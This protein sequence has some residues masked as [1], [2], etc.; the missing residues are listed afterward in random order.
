MSERLGARERIA[1]PHSDSPRISVII[2]SSAGNQ[3]LLGALRA[4]QHAA[5][6]EIPF[7]TIVI[8]N[9][10]EAGSIGALEGVTGIHLEPAPVNLGLAGAGNRGRSI[11]RGDLLVLLHDDAEVEPGW[12]EALV[13]TADGHP[14]AGAIGGKVLNMDGSLQNAG[15]ILWRDG[16][17]TAPWITPPAPSAFDRLRAVDYC[18]TSSL[19]VRSATWDAVGGLDE[20]FYPVYYVDVDL[21]MSIRALGQIVLCE[22]ASRIRH[23]RGAS[24]RRPWQLFLTAR[25]RERFAAKWRVEL[26]EHHE[27][28]A[29]RSP[30]AIDRAIARAEAFHAGVLQRG[31]SNPLTPGEPRRI[32]R[33]EHDLLHLNLALEVHKAY[34]SHLADQ[35]D[36]LQ[37]TRWWQLREPAR[38]LLDRFWRR[39]RS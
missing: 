2:P 7:E 16:S 38:S 11:A 30:H 36:A 24:G 5:P 14:E 25:N 39:R 10:A 22:P 4:L 3:F 26:E 37:K 17:T 34:A 20:Q 12:M 35:L 18:G 19:L 6:A 29:D 23:H 28:P 27:P 15:M 8:L 1:I 32:E 13:S 33:A 31:P 21:S 9:E